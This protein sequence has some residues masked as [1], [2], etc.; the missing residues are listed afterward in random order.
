MGSRLFLVALLAAGFS[1]AV[2]AGA[3]AAHEPPKPGTSKPLVGQPA[4]TLPL[5]D[6]VMGISSDGTISI[7]NIGDADVTKPFLVDTT[8]TV[9]TATQ[10]NQKCGSPYDAAGRWLQT[11]N[12]PPGHKQSPLKESPRREL[13][14]RYGPGWA[15]LYPP[16]PSWPKGV[17]RISGCANDDPVDPAKRIRE[18][19]RNNNCAFMDVPKN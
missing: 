12:L 6:I 17:Y 2:E 13:R 9:V 4:T 11:L 16:V 14:I 8:C 1:V 3:V 19:T 15:M 7:Q 10:S 5:P 18:K